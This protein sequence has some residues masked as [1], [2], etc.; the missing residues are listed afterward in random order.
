MYGG[1]LKQPFEP[2]NLAI[3]KATGKLFH[4]LVKPMVEPE[5]SKS[6]EYGLVRSSIAITL[7]DRILPGDADENWTFLRISG[8]LGEPIEWLPEE[9]E[10]GEWAM[11]D[12]NMQI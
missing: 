1:N 12:D 5:S 3:S 2:S 8:E 11:P 9:N 10:P 6:L 4:K 7:S